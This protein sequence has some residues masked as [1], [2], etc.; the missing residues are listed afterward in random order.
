MRITAK[1]WLTINFP[2][3]KKNPKY[4]LAFI[5]HLNL[6]VSLSHTHAA[7]REAGI[8]LWPQGGSTFPIHGE[9]ITVNNKHCS[10]NALFPVKYL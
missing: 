6:N 5:F 2:L 10:L 8:P 4:K 3:E 9:L 7:V 1:N